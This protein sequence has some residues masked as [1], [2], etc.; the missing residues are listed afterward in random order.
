MAKGNGERFRMLKLHGL[1]LGIFWGLTLLILVVTALFNKS[2]DPFKYLTPI[3][4]AG[5]LSGMAV[6]EVYCRLQKRHSIYQLYG[7]LASIR[8][9]G[10][11]SGPK[12]RDYYAEPDKRIGTS[13][14]DQENVQSLAHGD[15]AVESH[16][17]GMDLN[18]RGVMVRRTRTLRPR[19]N[20][21]ELVKSIS[22]G[23]VI[24]E[25]EVFHKRPLLGV[26]G[27]ALGTLTPQAVKAIS[28]GAARAG[29]IVN[30]GEGSIASYHVAGG[31]L[32]QIEFQF[33]TGYFG[34]RTLEGTFSLDALIEKI[35]QYPQIRSI[36]I[37]GSQ[38]AKAGHSGNLPKEKITSEIAQIRGIPMDR[39]C[40]GSGVHTAFV[41]EEGLVRFIE[42][43]R[44]ATG[45]PVTFKMAVGSVKEFDRLCSA[46]SLYPEGA[47]DA[48]QIDGGEGGTGS[49]YMEVFGQAA[50]PLLD[51]L[52]IADL[53][54][55][56]YHLRDRVKL[57]ASGQLFQADHIAR[58]MALGADAVVTARGAKYALGCIAAGLCHKAGEC[59]SGV[60]NNGKALDVELRAQYLANYLTSLVERLAMFVDPMGITDI[61]DL[62]GTRTQYMDIKDVQIWR[63]SDVLDRMELE[64]NNPIDELMTT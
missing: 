14:R 47:P 1:V 44:E 3:F 53:L 52:Q 63:L 54:L 7:Q 45:K 9:F 24:G 30:T 4:L 56:K 41:G 13:R 29:A 32:C 37:K 59:P 28:I 10:E 43:I 17:S 50:L 11:W 36:Q 26:S 21:G 39:D 51:A 18:R 38:G 27:M 5:H 62:V 64:G 22:R 15:L 2:F 58:A 60:A 48:I 16:K 40:V 35:R 25:G 23:V 12:G 33:G 19:D 46:I 8:E 55:R 42:Q 6:F 57:I 31:E 61:G 34:C 49:A 20:R